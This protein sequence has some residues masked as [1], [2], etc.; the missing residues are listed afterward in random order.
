MELQQQHG[1]TAAVSMQ[2]SSSAHAHAHAHIVH[3]K[4][5]QRTLPVMS[6]GNKLV[7]V[8]VERESANNPMIGTANATATAQNPSNSG[9]ATPNAATVPPQ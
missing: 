5:Q 1:Y 7:T 8:K 4:Q 6:F 9:A 3:A 2:T